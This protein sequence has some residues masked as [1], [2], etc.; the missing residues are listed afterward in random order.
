MS[1][2]Q[3]QLPLKLSSFRDNAKRPDFVDS[4]FGELLRYRAMDVN[5]YTYEGNTALIFG[6]GSSACESGKLITAD[7]R[8]DLNQPVL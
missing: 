1:F 5:A 7:L 3:L 2:R 4:T 8:T 6:A